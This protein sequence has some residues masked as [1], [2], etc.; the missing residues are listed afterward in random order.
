MVLISAVL[1]ITSTETN[2]CNSPTH[3]EATNQ[4]M[5]MY[6]GI[7]GKNNNNDC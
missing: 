2:Q 3:H 7:H 1:A 5:Y 6:H 4:Y